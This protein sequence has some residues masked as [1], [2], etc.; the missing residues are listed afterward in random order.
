M[1][2][3]E[4]RIDIEGE[5]FA[6]N[7]EAYQ[8][9]VT[10]LRERQQW[11]IDGGPGRERATGGGPLAPTAAAAAASPVGCLGCPWPPSHAGRSLAPWRR[12][13]PIRSNSAKATCYPT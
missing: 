9:L 5:Q 4:S 8:H 6:G 11:A 10:T 13:R 12:P 3:I 2:P 7:A 1:R